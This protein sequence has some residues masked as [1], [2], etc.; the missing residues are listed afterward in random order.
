MK[1]NFNRPVIYSSLLSEQ[2]EN[3]I[4]NHAIYASVV[5][6]EFTTRTP[7]ALMNGL[8]TELLIKNCCPDI[9]IKNLLWCNI[10]H[11]LASIKIASQGSDL[12]VLLRCPKCKANDP[13]EINL[14]NVIPYLTAKKW[15]TPLNIDNFEIA[16]QSPTYKN[17][18]DFSIEEFKL[19]KQL[20]Q[21]TQ[22]NEPETHGQYISSLMSQ[23]QELVGAYQSKYI[24]SVSVDGMLVD[25]PKY[26]REW[27]RQCDINLTVQLGKYIEEAIKE[28]SISSFAVTC[29][30][31]KFPFMVPIDLDQCSTFRQRLIPASQEEVLN[32][33]NQ[34]GE[35]TKALSDDL[36]KMVWYMR[37]GISYTEA[38]SLT[39]HE[40]KCIAKIIENNIEITKESGIAI[41]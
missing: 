11:L 25:E 13:Y 41:I 35:E 12:E 28:C 10:Q 20:Y 34:M 31:C 9:D 7:D 29:D 22:M 1:P 39:N 17:Y 27:Y 26:V 24:K 37:G 5:T 36:L 32:I 30:E 21:I 40:R 23:R 38:Y 16:L 4:N 6:D 33:I 19:N 2:A 15:F 3:M 18:S 8:A 14:Q